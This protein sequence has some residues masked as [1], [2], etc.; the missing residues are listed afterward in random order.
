[1]AE[2]LMD[3][4]VSFFSGDKEHLSDKEMLLRQTHKELSQNKYAKYFRHKTDEVDPSLA[5]FFFTLYK[6]T[7]PIRDFMHSEE[8]MA[9]LKK[10]ILE[11]FMDSSILDM[12]KRI[13]PAAIEE[14]ARTTEPAELASQIQM[15]VSRL[16]SAF[17]DSRINRA[18]RCYNL[19]AALSQMVNFNFPGLLKKF[20]P[21]FMEGGFNIE[22]KFAAIRADIPARDIGEFLVVS[23]A[24]NPEGDW[25][26]LLD[27]LKNCA[28]H[29]LVAPERFA[30][31]ITGLRDVHQSKI[32]E[33][34]TQYGL[35]NPVWQWK[36][37]TP[38]EHIG[39]D[40][41]E[42]RQAEAQACINKINIAQKNIQ[43]AALVKQVFESADL[44]RLE[45]YTTAKGEV[46]RQR[47]LEDFVYANGLNYLCVFLD[48]YLKREVQELCD[49]LLIR[50]QWTRN[51]MSKEMS[52]ALHQLLDALP[53]ILELDELLSED[54]GDGSRLKAAILRV[55]RDRTQARYIN[56][57]VDSSNEKALEA[58]NAA[59]QNFIVIGKHL[60]SLIE[61][62]QKKHPELIINWR[63]LNLA[64]KTPLTQ[65]M[66]DDYRKINYFIQLMQL[67]TR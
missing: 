3:K 28:G 34:I 49:I 51:L 47:N 6:T 36:P 50:G 17:D 14:R 60:K 48:D 25:K 58:I 4:V 53:P 29:D 2:D 43:I 39:E 21:N 32:L 57:I 9:R 61:D 5:V 12:A 15:D 30:A 27:L 18:N 22:P 42:T 64:S 41:L 62:V 46:L 20:D 11:A 66:I 63:E 16:H 7:F 10:I 67:C 44:N 65:R 8:K 59:A 40:W 31:M 52:E 45:N 37:K 35:K 24:L 38:D 33:L 56:S 13:S 55:D 23:H 26:T 1:M 54:G 19:V